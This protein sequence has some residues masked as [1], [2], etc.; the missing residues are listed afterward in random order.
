[1]SK[2]NYKIVTHNFDMGPEESIVLSFEIQLNR[3][4]VCRLVT[5]P[6]NEVNETDF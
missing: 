6:S 2:E 5:F 4:D 3:W 1:M